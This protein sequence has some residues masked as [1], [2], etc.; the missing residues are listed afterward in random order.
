MRFMIAVILFFLLVLSALGFYRTGQIKSGVEA[1]WPPIGQFVSVNNGR[2]HLLDLG[3]KDATPGRTLVLIHGA[4]SNLRD[5]LGSIAPSLAQKYR[6]ILIDRPGHGWSE[7]QGG[8]GDSRLERQAAMIREA[9]AGIGV[10]NAVLGGHSWAG[11]LVMRMAIDDPD[12][13]EGVILLSP[14]THPWPGG[15]SWYY[16]VATTP[17]LGSYFTN[18]VVAPI[19]HLTFDQAVAGVFTPS[20]APSDYASKTGAELLLRP[21]EFLANSEDVRDLLPQVAAQIS[22]YS[23]LKMPALIISADTDTVV[24]PEIHSRT[25]A[26]ALP[27]SRLVIMPGA[28]HVPH[29]SRTDA[30]LAEIGGFLEKQATRD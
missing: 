30:V 27:N 8:R 2:I 23:A 24:S 19:A 15:V 11:A 10:K 25:V 28:G 14:V 20:V 13:T 26:K 1:S 12:L 22:R 17:V 16:N 18:I 3:P 4:S 7:R 9:L 29:H 6:V 21:Q 5:M